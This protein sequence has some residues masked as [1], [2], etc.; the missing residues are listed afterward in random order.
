MKNSERNEIINK[1]NSAKNI[2]ELFVIG[3][4][5]EPKIKN[6]DPGLRSLVINTYFDKKNRL[7]K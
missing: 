7:E 1:I 5:T 3:C 6:E 4:E 2:T